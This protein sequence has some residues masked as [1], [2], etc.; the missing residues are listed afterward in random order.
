MK[1]IILV[2]IMAVFAFCG[3]E[4]NPAGALMYNGV[5]DSDSSWANP[6]ILYYNGDIRTMVLPFDDAIGAYTNIWEKYS[7]NQNILEAQYKGVSHSGYMSIKMGWDGRPSE[8]FDSNSTV[9][10]V[11]F[12][13]KTTADGSSKKLSGAG[14]TKFSFWYKAELGSDTEVTINIFDHGDHLFPDFTISSGSGWT[15]KEID[16]SLYNSDA[17]ETYISVTMRPISPAASCGGGTIYL[18]D[19]RLSK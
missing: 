5:Y 7:S 3:C 1:K 17:V 19:I 11:A 10:N 14:Y 6:F 4:R 9:N 8:T 13:L 15:Y 2:L 16:I 18:D 12:W